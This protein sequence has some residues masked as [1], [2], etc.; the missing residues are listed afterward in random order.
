MPT[1]DNFEK[2]G[3]PAGGFVRSTGMEIDWQDGPLTENPRNGAFVEE[4][5]EAA[6]VRIEYYQDSKFHCLENAVALGHL[7]AALE[8]LHE[9][10]RERT[11]RGVEGSHK[12]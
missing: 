9:R 4:V 1:Y 6:I 10:T 2:D 11:D 8:A 3:M 12:K 7:Y 5:I